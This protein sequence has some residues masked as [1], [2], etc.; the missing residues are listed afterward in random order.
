MET[1]YQENYIKQLQRLINSLY[2]NEKQYI[3]ASHQI[4][5]EEMKNTF[6]HT[7]EHRSSLITELEDAIRKLGGEVNTDSHHVSD[8]HQGDNTSADIKKE[9]AVLESLRKSEQDTL[10][11]YDD[12]L[13]GTILEEFNLKTLIMSQRLAISDSFTELDRRYFDM[14]KL[15]QPY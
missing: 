9:Q 3:K 13:Q 1:S 15:K 7:A 5:N 2:K 14:F 10:D 6:R 4:E 8:L 11:T 12:V